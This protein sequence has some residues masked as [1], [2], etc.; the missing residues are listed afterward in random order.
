MNSLETHRDVSDTGSSLAELNEYATASR[1]QAEDAEARGNLPLA[2]E[3]KARAAEA[4][5]LGRES[6]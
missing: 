4:E 2:R 6:D 3:L 5:V 1:L